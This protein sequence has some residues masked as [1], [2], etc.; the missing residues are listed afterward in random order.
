MWV[1]EEACDRNKP[2]SV[3]FCHKGN[4]KCGFAGGVV[5]EMAD[6]SQDSVT[7]VMENVG[8]QEML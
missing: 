2:E 3:K 1:C 4:E 7:R 6:L 5:T 8:L